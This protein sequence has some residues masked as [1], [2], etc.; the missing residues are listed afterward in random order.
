MPA[1]VK[2][3]QRSSKGNIMGAHPAV[4]TVADRYCAGREVVDADRPPHITS[5]VTGIVFTAG[6]PAESPRWRRRPAGVA[7]R[8]PGGAPPPSSAAAPQLN[9]PCRSETPA[10]FAA[11]RA[12]QG[13]S[14]LPGA[15]GAA[16]AA[17]HAPLGLAR[18]LGVSARSASSPMRS[19]CGVAGAKIVKNGRLW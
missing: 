9:A 12:A 10:G 16:A 7:A 14:E 3:K 8:N 2:P 11:P 13:R 1:V 18:P 19:S 5:T 4:N 15:E 6:S 17:C